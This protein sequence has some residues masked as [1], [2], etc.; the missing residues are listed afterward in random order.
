MIDNIRL[1]EVSLG[2][3]KEQ[4]TQSEES[5]SKARRSIVAKDYISIGEVLSE[6]NITTKRPF[7][8][9]NTPA[10][11]WDNIIGL[12]STKNYKPDDFI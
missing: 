9:G 7:L 3:K 12:K 11:E 8:E 5:F 6:D 4:Y 10:S 2:S 1:T